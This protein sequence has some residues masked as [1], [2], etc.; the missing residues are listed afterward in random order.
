MEISVH[1]P[2]EGMPHLE[3]TDPKKD[4]LFNLRVYQSHNERAGKKKIEMFNKAELA[5][6]KRTGLTPVFFA[7][8]IFGTLMPNLTYMLVFPDEAG[9]KAAWDKFKADPEWAKLKAMPEYLD[10]EIVLKVDNYILTP[11]AYSQL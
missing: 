11:A 9:R 3:M 8:T 10:S 4:R 1:L 5:I 6:F 7:E 2:I